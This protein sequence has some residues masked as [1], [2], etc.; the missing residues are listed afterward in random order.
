[1]DD[2]MFD[3][4]RKCAVE[5]LSVDEPAMV[6]GRQVRRRPRRR[7]PRPGRAGHGA[8]GGVRR[9]RRRGR[10]RGH[11][12]RRP[13][14]RPGRPPSSDAASEGGTGRRVVVTGIGVVAP[15]GIGEDA[16]WEGLPPAGAAGRAASWSTTSTPTPWFDNPKEVRRAD[17]FAQ[18]AAGRGRMALEQTAASRP[19]DPMRRGVII[20]TGVGGLDTLEEQIQVR[21]REGRAP[22]V[23]VPRPDDDGQRRRRLGLDALRLAGPVRDHRDRLRGRHPLDRQRRPAHRLRP[24][25]RRDHRRHRERP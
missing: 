1:M 9:H 19:A 12:D 14:L 13:G 17:R 10:A 16:F 20:G 5:V 24:L 23:A 22:G 11:R 15:C 8:R 18:F 21:L 3:R 4:F 6:P 2:E 25:R 7:Q